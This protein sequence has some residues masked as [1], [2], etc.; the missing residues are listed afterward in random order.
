MKGN[1]RRLPYPLALVALG[2]V[3][4]FGAALWLSLP[5]APRPP[6]DAVPAAVAT[7]GAA[8]DEPIR[9]IPLTVTLD[10]RKV[11]LGRRLFHDPR[12]SGD[13]RI[14]CAS[15]HDLRTGGTDHLARSIGIG[16]READVNAPT[17]FN[18]SLNFKQFWDGRADTLEAQIDGPVQNPK[19]MGSGWP[20]VLGKLRQDPSYVSAF[21][22][23]YPDGI[24]IHTIQDAIATFERSLLTPNAPFDRY[25]R[26]DRGAISEQAR[27]G[28]LLFK[29]LGCVACHQ[30]VNVGGNM[31]QKFGVM[32][33]YFADRGNPTPADLGRF[34]VTGQEQDRHTFK[35]PGLRNVD[36]TAPYFHDG[37]AKT[38]PQA[39]AIMG[40]Y[41]LGRPLSAAEIELLVAFLK[42]LTGEYDGESL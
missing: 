41:Q 8:R 5:V 22:G 39:V 11:A 17:V 16:G 19:E 13:N 35:V 24:Q 37:S 30:G 28:Y 21:A 4:T 33:D 7:D 40:Q 12:L 9:P 6:A 2:M 29:K 23:L 26:G 31:F 10:P 1:G 32:A 42:T 34:N 14:A 36:R 18:S 15:C 20:E 3:G 38:L 27:A 25:L